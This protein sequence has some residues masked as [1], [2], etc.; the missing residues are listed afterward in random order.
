[1]ESDILKLGIRLRNSS[2]SSVTVTLI[3]K[4]KQKMTLSADLQSDP[5][6]VSRNL[7]C[8]THLMQFLLDLHTDPLRGNPL[9]EVCQQLGQLWV[10]LDLC[11]SDIDGEGGIHY[12]YN[13]TIYAILFK[14]MYMYCNQT[15]LIHELE[16]LEFEEDKILQIFLLPPYLSS[17]LRTPTCNKKQLLVANQFMGGEQNKVISCLQYIVHAVDVNKKLCSILQHIICSC[18]ILSLQE[19]HTQGVD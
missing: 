2:F 17:N 1:M 11:G 14:Y 9:G 4:K 18:I 10:V 5:L 13:K 19:K 12:R 15:S 16:K 7:H 8:F 3:D 6:N